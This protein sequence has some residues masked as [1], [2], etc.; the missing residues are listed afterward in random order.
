VT[1]VIPRTDDFDLSGAGDQPAWRTAEWIDLLR[2]GRGTAPY[3]TRARALHSETGLYLL[4]DCEDRKISCTNLKDFDDLWT[5]DVVEAFIQPNPHLPVYFEYEISPLGAELPIL[6]SNSGGAFMGWRPWHYEEERRIRRAAAVRGGPGA[7][8]AAVE[9]WTAEC[10][11]PFALLK[12][13]SGVPPGDCA[14]WRANFYRIDYD[15]T[16]PTHWAWRDP[17]GDT[18]H[19]P[20]AFGELVFSA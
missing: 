13:L 14:R 2:V 18:F 17:C 8:G 12:G 6:V 16:P 19:N 20:A 11:I 5:E 3:R 9:G 7:P 10:F 4:F 15:E 1:Y